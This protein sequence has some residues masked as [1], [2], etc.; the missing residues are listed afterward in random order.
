[1]VYIR[2]A[3]YIQIVRFKLDSANAQELADAVQV[4]LSDWI[5]KCPGFVSANLHVSDDGQHMINY[6]QW[7]DKDSFESFVKSADQ[8]AL[9]KTI[10]KFKPDNVESN[11]FELVAQQS[12]EDEFWSKP[13]F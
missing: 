7:R 13:R 11:H 6:A 4:H 9:T 1:M 10:D 2:E 3:L 5:S 12:I 8:E